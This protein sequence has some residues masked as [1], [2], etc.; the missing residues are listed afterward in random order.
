MMKTTSCQWRPRFRAV[1]DKFLFPRL[2]A[3]SSHCPLRY[4]CLF[5][6]RP[7]LLCLRSRP[8]ILSFH[9]SRCISTTPRMLGCVLAVSVGVSSVLR[10]VEKWAKIQNPRLATLLPRVRCTHARE[11]CAR[12]KSRTKKYASSFMMMDLTTKISLYR[13]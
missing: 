2:G 5:V 12:T 8:W 4:P 7:F 6:S 3:T 11:T 1:L 10:F 13:G 9:S